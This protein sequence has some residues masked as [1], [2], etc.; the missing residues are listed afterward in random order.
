MG[1]VSAFWNAFVLP[2]V[3]TAAAQRQALDIGDDIMRRAAGE[4][5]AVKLA[6]QWTT[7]NRIV[8]DLPALRLRDFSI[9]GTAGVPTLIVAPYALHDAAVAD[10]AVG[11]SLVATLRSSCAGPLFLVEWK[12]ADVAMRY[13][14]ID[15]LFEELNVAVDEC[16]GY[17][18][19]I[20][21]C[22]GG[23]LSFA[24]A[25]RFPTKVR[26]LVLAGAPIDIAVE[27][28]MISRAAKL[29][30]RELVE[31]GIRIGGGLAGGDRLLPVW[32]YDPD[33][34]DAAASA[35]QIDLPPTNGP[36]PEAFTSFRSWCRRTLNLPGTYFLQ[37][38]EW[39]FC[40]NRIAAGTFSALG[41]IVDPKLIRTPLYVLGGSEDELTSPRQALAAG[42]LVGTPRASITTVMV[43]CGHLALFMGQRTLAGEWPRIGRWLAAP[44]VSRGA[45]CEKRLRKIS[46]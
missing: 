2:W 5:N 10:I 40:E 14:S 39:L 17:C 32:G 16:G 27:P 20:G 8:L 13:F 3:A 11:H 35:L 42:S 22:Q 31:E 4:A 41:K 7:P 43:P 30:S 9:C 34:T 26:R 45:D 23:W 12:S 28:S 1:E 6:P 29:L 37:V 36:R 18:N 38:H 19:L 33:D 21:L 24:F 44:A 46:S 15:T 25:A